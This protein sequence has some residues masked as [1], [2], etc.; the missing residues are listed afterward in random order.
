MSEPERKRGFFK[1]RFAQDNSYQVQAETL[2][3]IGRSGG[4]D[5]LPYLRDASEMPSH[6]D[7]IRQA[8]EWAIEEISKGT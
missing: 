1:E 3:A 5:Q 2:R 7:V 8:A 6:Q 4:T